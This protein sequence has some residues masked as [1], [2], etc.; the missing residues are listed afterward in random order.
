MKNIE[1]KNFEI[2]K[3]KLDTIKGGVGVIE[4]VPTGSGKDGITGG[5]VNESI[6]VYDDGCWYIWYEKE[7]GTYYWPFQYC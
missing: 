3:S 5:T 4:I 1:F 2:E 6:V 7:D